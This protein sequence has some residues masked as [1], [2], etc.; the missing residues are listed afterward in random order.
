MSL[1]ITDKHTRSSSSMICWW[2]CG[3]CTPSLRLESTISYTQTIKL[4]CPPKYL[5]W[6]L[7]SFLGKWSLL[8]SDIT[9]LKC[10]L[11]YLFDCSIL[12][13]SS[14]IVTVQHFLS[15]E[16]MCLG[17]LYWK[18]SRTSLFW[19]WSLWNLVLMIL[20]WGLFSNIGHAQLLAVLIW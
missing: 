12:N 5:F 15:G 4:H 16:R 17:C 6:P 8:K 7:W 9:C 10:L 20:V 11:N 13:E 19:Q 3:E 14:S 2:S 18:K 1:R